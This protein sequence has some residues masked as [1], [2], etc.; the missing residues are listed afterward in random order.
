[1]LETPTVTI[2]GFGAFGALA[3]AALA[4]HLR[5]VVHDPCPHARASA[6]SS[7]FE[8]LDD[9]ARIGGDFILLAVPVPAMEDCLTHLAPHLRPGQVVIDTC[10][11]KEEPARMMRRVLPPGVEGL[12]T[13]P[14]FGPNSAARGVRGLRIV[15][16]PQGERWRRIAAFLRARLGL[17]VILA[18]PEDH[19]R[20]AAVGQG[21]V[22]LLARAFE[23]V[24]APMIRTR[25]FD[26]LSD[27]FA[28]V[29]SDPPEVF[30]AVTRGNPHMADARERLVRAITDLS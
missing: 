3:A 6:A 20:Q 22:H 16:C 29:R 17:R 10:S 4:P 19:D 5:I 7:G 26:L 28:M 1:M 2:I 11:I 18:T 25:S 24:G 21:L 23:A 8:V 9:P 27:A 12:P 30:A 13:H 15:I 14:M